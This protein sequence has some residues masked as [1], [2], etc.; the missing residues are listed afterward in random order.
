MTSLASKVFSF[1]APS[2]LGSGL[3]KEALEKNTKLTLKTATSNDL[4]LFDDI[5]YL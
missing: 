4:M 2:P 1:L 3:A 5:I